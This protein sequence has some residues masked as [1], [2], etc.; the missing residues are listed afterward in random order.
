MRLEKVSSDGLG[1]ASNLMVTARNRT[2]KE[3][4]LQNLKM[5][6]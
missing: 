1:L 5:R 4:H 2:L 3:W 6:L